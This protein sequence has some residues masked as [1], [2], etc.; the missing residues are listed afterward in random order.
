M[1]AK[2]LWRREEA[3]RAQPP[4]VTI[5]ILRLALDGGSNELEAWIT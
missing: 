1:Y 2:L 5:T 3:P 4:M